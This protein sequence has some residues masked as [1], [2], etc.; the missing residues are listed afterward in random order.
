M[1]SN[2]AIGTRGY[3]LSGAGL[4]NV[5]F[6]AGGLTHTHQNRAA[7]TRINVTPAQVGSEV[8][9]VSGRGIGMVG[10]PNHQVVLLYR[11]STV[12][13]VNVNAAL[14]NIIS[15]VGLSREYSHGAEVGGNGLFYGGLGNPALTTC[16]I[17]NWAGGMVKQQ[18]SVAPARSIPKGCSVDY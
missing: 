4:S 17:L 8:S 16:T 6:F 12:W 11:S 10:L 14:I 2:E 18:S 1:S 5:G 13:R 3:S 7:L 9:I 15:G